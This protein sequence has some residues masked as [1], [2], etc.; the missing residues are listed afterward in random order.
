MPIM[1]FDDFLQNPHLD[2]AFC[3]KLGLPQNKV[4]SAVEKIIQ[5]VDVLEALCY[6]RAV[7][8]INVL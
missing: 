7:V 3:E 1:N 6:K 5:N 4:S 2:T 8:K